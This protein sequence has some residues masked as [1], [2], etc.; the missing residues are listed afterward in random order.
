M[1]NRGN[2]LMTEQ[3]NV[4]TQPRTD[5]EIFSRG[6]H[7]ITEQDNITTQPRTDQEIFNRGNHLITAQYHRQ[8]SISLKIFDIISTIL[9]SSKFKQLNSI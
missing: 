1:F 8:F 6:N 4:T 9:F 3:E 2:H 5:Q 7:L